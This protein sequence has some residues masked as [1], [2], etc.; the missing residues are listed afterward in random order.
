MYFRYVHWTLNHTLWDKTL[1]WGKKKPDRLP[2]KRGKK[3]VSRPESYFRKKGRKKKVSCGNTGLI[4]LTLH[5]CW[6][7]FSQNHIPISFKFSIHSEYICL[8]YVLSFQAFSNVNF[9]MLIILISILLFLK[10]W[11]KIPKRFIGGL[12]FVCLFVFIITVTSSH[13]STKAGLFLSNERVPYASFNIGF[14]RH[15]CTR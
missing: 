6:V 3:S 11:V 15:Y 8:I 7:L 4:L 14:W 12:F 1:L 5:V 2:K 13:Q 9:K 10:M